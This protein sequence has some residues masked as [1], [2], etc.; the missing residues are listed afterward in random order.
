[1]TTSNGYVQ[2]ANDWKKE[3]TTTIYETELEEKI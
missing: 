1:M 2:N 3:K